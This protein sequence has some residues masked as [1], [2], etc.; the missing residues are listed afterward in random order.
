MDALENCPITE[1]P[2]KSS[3]VIENQ[4]VYL[5][6]I[7][8]KNMGIKLPLDYK[9][10]D[11]DPIYKENKYIVA[12]IFL[13]GQ[14][15]YNFDNLGYILIALDDIKQRLKEGGYPHSAQEKY[16]N[17]FLNLFARQTYDGELVGP[18]NIH[19][20]N[21]PS[22]YKKL[23]FRTI[24]EFHFYARSL[25]VAGLIDGGFHEYKDQNRY[26]LNQ[27]RITYKGLSHLVQL[28]SEGKNSK[29]CFIAMSF[30]DSKD[31]KDIREAIKAACEDT[32]YTPY[33][34]DEKHYHSASTINDAIIAGLRACRF[35]IADFTE[36][37]KGVYFESGFALGQDKQV[38]YCCRNDSF[39]SHFDTNHFPH[40]LYN[41]PEELK[42]SLINKIEAWIR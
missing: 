41:T 21:D 16:D 29:N 15:V 27:Y 11:T 39:D 34:V 17:L 19:N 38:I 24:E 25:H 23:F 40:I 6:D 22:Y 30:S 1:L 8:G 14:F 13:N 10:W 28:Q 33:L 3:H 37:K 36:Q 18:L 9:Q 35:C 7:D 2:A 26:I 5:I 20:S 42:K 12:S 32:G 4:Y 31:I